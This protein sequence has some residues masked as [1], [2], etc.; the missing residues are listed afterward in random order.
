MREREKWANLLV[1]RLVE[2]DKVK[3]IERAQANKVLALV[4]VVQVAGLG[5]HA[6]EDGLDVQEELLVEDV[7]AA[8]LDHA[9][10]IKLLRHAVLHCEGK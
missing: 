7:V 9:R 8:H 2:Q 3:Y 5:G 6:R 1:R 10:H 4:D